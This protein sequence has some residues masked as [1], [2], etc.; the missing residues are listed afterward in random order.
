MDSQK[1]AHPG[2][3]LFFSNILYFI[4]NYIYKLRF[5]VTYET[6]EELNVH[7]PVLI[8]C[9]HSSNHDIPIGYP[10]ILKAF[11]R[12]AWCIIKEE[13]TK[14]IFFNFFLKIGGIP[15]DRKNPEKS[16]QSLFFAKKILN[17]GN[18][19]VLFPEQS[20]YY[21]KMGRGKLPGF[22]FLA[23]KPTTPIAVVCVGYEYRTGFF[24]KK[25]KIRLGNLQYFS[26]NDSSETFLHNCMVRIANLSNLDYP[27]PPPESK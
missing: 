17:E 20:R 8:L 2:K 18:M 10:I 24:R 13:L 22:R 5:S 23:G 1:F 19:I 4:G 12:H 16:K 14:P 27:F 7:G 9:K 11:K 6:Q 25:V 26:K 3:S 21:Q 15:V